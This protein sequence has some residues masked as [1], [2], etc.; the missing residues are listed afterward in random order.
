M[1][2]SL[3]FLKSDRKTFF[4]DIQI[5]VVWELQVVH[6]SHNTGQVVVR[7]IGRLAWAAHDCKDGGET[8]E[9]CVLLLANVNESHEMGRLTPN[10]KFRATSD[11][12][13]EITALLVV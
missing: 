9:T 2:C 6:A 5:A 8:L 1:E 11:E 7:G 10:G 12:L 3:S 4:E 13:K